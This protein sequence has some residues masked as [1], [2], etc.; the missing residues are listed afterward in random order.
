MGVSTALAGGEVAGVG[1][2]VRSA[3]EHPC[4]HKSKRDVVIKGS[5]LARGKMVCVC[6]SWCDGDDRFKTRC[7]CL[8]SRKVALVGT[9]DVVVSRRRG[10]FL[11]V[12]VVFNILQEFGNPLLLVGVP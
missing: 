6:E 8:F 9:R 10:F 3:H 1:R 12:F 5:I 2:S 4:N 7:H 11:E